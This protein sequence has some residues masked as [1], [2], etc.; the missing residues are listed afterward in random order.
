MIGA[1]QSPMYEGEG[2]CDGPDQDQSEITGCFVA[3]GTGVD[4][5]AVAV[6]ERAA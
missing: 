1:D 5:R 3:V 6:A 4:R 2:V